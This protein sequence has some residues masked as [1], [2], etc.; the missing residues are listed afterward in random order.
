MSRMSHRVLNEDRKK[1][2]SLEAGVLGDGSKST[3]KLHIV[4]KLFEKY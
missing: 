1:E 2:Q 3:L 4:A